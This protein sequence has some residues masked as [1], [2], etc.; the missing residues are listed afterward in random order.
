MRNA[1]STSPFEAK[2]PCR[3]NDWRISFRISPVV[4]EVCVVSFGAE[5]FWLA[6]DGH[7]IVDFGYE[8]LDQVA[9]IQ[10]HC[11]IAIQYLRGELMVALDEAGY[12]MRWQGGRIDLLVVP[13]RLLQY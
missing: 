2:P 1:A 5:D 10:E 7:G 4:Q 13:R 12:F 8:T 3:A 11:E 6:I 9:I